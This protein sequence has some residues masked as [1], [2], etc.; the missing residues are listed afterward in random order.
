MK[1]SNLTRKNCGCFW[2]VYFEENIFNSRIHHKFD[3]RTQ[4]SVIFWLYLKHIHIICVSYMSYIIYDIYDIWYLTCFLFRHI[5]FKAMVE[6]TAC[7]FPN[8]DWNS[9]ERYNG[10]GVLDSDLFS[11]GW[12]LR[13]RI[14]PW[15]RYGQAWDI[16]N[17]LRDAQS[18]YQVTNLGEQIYWWQL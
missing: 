13:L 15:S 8:H 3:G 4:I 2:L 16:D 14:L 17:A 18:K 5:E 10:S 9:D 6:K 1:F 11:A 12:L 7:I